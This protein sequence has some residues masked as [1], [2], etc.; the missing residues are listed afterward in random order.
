MP[1]SQTLVSRHLDKT[2]NTTLYIREKRIPFPFKKLQKWPSF[3]VLCPGINRGL[4]KTMTI[5]Q[6]PWNI[7][8]PNF[9]EGD[10]ARTPTHPRLGPHPLGSILTFQI[11]MVRWSIAWVSHG[12]HESPWA[13]HREWPPINLNAG[14][15]YFIYDKQ[16]YVIYKLT[17]CHGEYYAYDMYWRYHNV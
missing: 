16:G 3:W 7:K 8:S 10:I 17:S 9:W 6:D 1:I 11:R 14:I 2:K 12:Y 5:G 13:R 15:S 4:G